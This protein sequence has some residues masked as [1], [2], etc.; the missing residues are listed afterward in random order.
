MAM[1]IQSDEGL[2]Q[3]NIGDAVRATGKPQMLTIIEC[4]S[5]ISHV[6]IETVKTI[7]YR[8]EWRHPDGQIRSWWYNAN[9]LEKFR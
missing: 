7:Y 6:H 4:K 1:H 2:M 9:S 8:C 5:A 3:F